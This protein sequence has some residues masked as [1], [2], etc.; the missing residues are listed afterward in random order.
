MFAFTASLETAERL[1]TEIEAG[2]LSINHLG[3]GLPELHFG[4]M[5]DS[6]YG[7]EGGN[8]VLA[9]YQDTRMISRRRA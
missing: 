9:A 6:G 1:T 8:E 5:K 2:M 3:I 7:T 4:G